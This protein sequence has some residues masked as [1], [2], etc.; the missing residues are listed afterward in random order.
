MTIFYLFY[1][2]LFC[3]FITDLIKSF[4]ETINLRLAPVKHR[5]ISFHPT[6]MKKNLI[7]ILFLNF[8]ISPVY[9][10]LGSLFLPM[11]V[12]NGISIWLWVSMLFVINI[13]GNLLALR[14]FEILDSHSIALS[15][16]TI[17]LIY[18]AAILCVENC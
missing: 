4:N 12:N 8:S 6:S 3:K 1:I 17:S 9:W 18:G 15:I 14:K 7:L 2:I 5:R 10:A 11:L 16:A 13:A